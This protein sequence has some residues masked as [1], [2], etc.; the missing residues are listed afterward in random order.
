LLNKELW[1]YRFGGEA[2]DWGRYEE[3]GEEFWGFGWEDGTI[4]YLN[5][6][7]FMLLIK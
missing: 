6:R 5:I 7:L 3:A 2:E 1:F 4:V